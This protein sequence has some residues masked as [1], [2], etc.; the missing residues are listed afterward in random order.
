MYVCIYDMLELSRSSGPDDLPNWVLKEFAYVL[1]LSITDILNSSFHEQKVPFLWKMASVTPLPKDSII[2]D[3]NKDMR[4]ISLTSTL[5]KISE[6]ITIERGLKSHIL[7]FIDPCQFG[8]LPGFSTTLA[9]IS[10]IHHWLRDTVATSSTVRAILLDYRKAFDLVDHNLLMY[11]LKDL[12]V[13]PTVINWIA[14]FLK[15]RTQRVKLNNSCF[16]DWFDIPAGVPQGTRLGPWLFF[17]N[18]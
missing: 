18:D 2:S 11:R 1:A 6:S 12:G 13:K 9:L 4:P 3:F 8:F 17:D 15:N 14:D 10:M 7:S 5:S 16:S